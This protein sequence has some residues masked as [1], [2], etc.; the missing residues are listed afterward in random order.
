[1][2]QGRRAGFVAFRWM[3]RNSLLATSDEADSR[4]AFNERKRLILKGG[5]ATLAALW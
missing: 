1:L 5:S 3:L 2:L 4:F